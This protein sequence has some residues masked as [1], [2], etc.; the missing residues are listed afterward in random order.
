MITQDDAQTLT[1]NELNEIAIKFDRESNVRKFTGIPNIIM[2]GLLILFAVYVVWT[3]LFVILPEQVRRSAFVGIMMFIGYLYFPFIKGN[4]KRV[5]Y[6][7]WYDIVLAVLGAGAFFYY[8]FN[9]EALIGRAALI[10]S[11][12]I[13]IGLLGM[14]LLAE[15][16]RRVVGFP[17][18][19]IAGAF[20]IYA[21][22]DGYSLRRVVHQLFYTTEGIIGIPIGVA[23]TFIV[24]FI[25]LASFLEKSGVAK[26]FIDLANSVAGA[27]SGGPAK[28]AVITS[29]LL[30]M[31]SGSSVANT[32]ASGGVTIPAMK[33]TGYKPEFAAA[34]EA[35][36]STGGQVVPPI[37]GAAAFIM[38]EITGIPYL[39]IAVAAIIPAV[40][41]FTGVFIMVHLE[42]KKTGLKG[43]PKD[44]LP[45]FGRLVL[46]RG[47]L[48]L[49]IV[50]LVILLS[51]GFTPA[52]AACGAIVSVFI[53][54]LFRKE[55]RFTPASF[56][57]AVA[58][59]SRNTIGIAIACA[60][61]G[62][63]V[64]IVTLTGIGQVLIRLLVVVVNNPF[65]V[66]INASLFAALII[67]A[68]ACL[69]LGL[70]VPTTAKYVI[71]ATIT[72]PMILRAGAEI[73]IVVPLLAAHMFVFHFGTDA[74]I[75][76]PVGLASYAAAAIAKSNPLTTCVIAMKLAIAGYIIPFFFVFSPELLLVGATPLLVVKIIISSVA[77]MFNIAVG[78]QGFLLQ[79][80]HWPFRIIIIVAGFLL[81]DP[82]IITTLAGFGISATIIFIHYMQYKRARHGH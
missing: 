17:I 25:F 39:T 51:R 27:S 47:Y 48:I 11:I 7:P 41:Y 31:I 5:N 61:A 79:K 35:A 75:T 65:L 60:V 53:I 63:V 44:T 80:M 22:I 73:G 76:P 62:T 36:S 20:V 4:T 18:V 12:D 19:I 55:T 28:V 45:K 67:T 43:L 26:F 10:N 34:V 6:I 15:L 81:I 50:V 37:L 57:E 24:L 23:S 8:S 14:I 52:Y 13:Y 46:S 16:C 9:F 33:K 1:Q 71:M 56:V 2:K 82:A 69:I 77:G 58:T 32:V 38:A 66:S 68:L 30:G 21:F 59:G 72:A 74:D 42:A 64:G 70:G 40:L 78:V 54:T 29:A 49:P 3:T